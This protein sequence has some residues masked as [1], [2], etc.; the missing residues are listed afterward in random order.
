MK[1]KL[2]KSL[3]P[4]NVYY[5]EQL[6]IFNYMKQFTNQSFMFKISTVIFSK[7]SITTILFSDYYIILFV[8]FILDVFSNCNHFSFSVVVPC[9]KLYFSISISVS[10]NILTVRLLVR[11]FGLFCSSTLMVS[12]MIKR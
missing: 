3:K 6:C 12:S 9:F 8:H 11:L 1:S 5:K 10:V 2:L 4:V 7:Q